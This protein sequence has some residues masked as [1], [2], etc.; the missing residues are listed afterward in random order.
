MPADT[1]A[2]I[3]FI[4][5]IRVLGLIVACSAGL[6]A[7]PIVGPLAGASL[8]CAGIVDLAFGW[9]EKAATIRKTHRE[10]KNL[11][12]DEE[13]KEYELQLK[14]LELEKARANARPNI[15]Y[16]S[17]I[18]RAVVQN[19]VRQRGITEGYANHM[20][21]RTLPTYQQFRRYMPGWR[22]TTEYVNP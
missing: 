3:P 13:I 17:F 22:I 15:P 10:E 16:S 7:A 1:G 12:L 20:L 4:L 9:R 11:E 5:P 2:K 8:V 21:N 6:V 19:Y 18:P 14:R